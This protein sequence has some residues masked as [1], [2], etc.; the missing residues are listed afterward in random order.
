MSKF[1]Y[2]FCL[3]LEFLQV[4]TTDNGE[5]HK[6]IIIFVIFFFQS[7]VSEFSF[8]FLEKKNI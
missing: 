5:L 4:N 7:L 8:R 6:N 3:F 2:V 1:V